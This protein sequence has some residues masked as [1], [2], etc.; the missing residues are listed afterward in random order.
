MSARN[1]GK[2]AG[3]AAGVVAGAAAVSQLQAKRLDA[4]GVLLNNSLAERADPSTIRRDEVEAIG[5]K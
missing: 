2:I 3:A 4:A 1:V 5:D